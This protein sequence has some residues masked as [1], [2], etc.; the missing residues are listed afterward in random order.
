MVMS[1]SSNDDLTHKNIDIYGKFMA[2]RALKS[3]KQ[4]TVEFSPE[5]VLQKGSFLQSTLEFS[6]SPK[7]QQIS[8][9]WSYV[10]LIA[11]KNQQFW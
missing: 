4:L 3:C 9:H 7:F 5:S 6:Y 1:A 11:L 10:L 8:K 2:K